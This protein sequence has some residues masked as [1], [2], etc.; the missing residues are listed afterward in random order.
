MINLLITQIGELRGELRA[1][2][3]SFER[4]CGD[5]QYREALQSEISFLKGEAETAVHELKSV[6]AQAGSIQDLE[7]LKRKIH[8]DEITRL[9]NRVRQLKEE[10][11][12]LKEHIRRAN[13]DANVLRRN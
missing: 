5:E 6:T 1:L 10:E 8:H 4:V 3:L 7:K 13:E 2:I 9:E 12:I 11:H